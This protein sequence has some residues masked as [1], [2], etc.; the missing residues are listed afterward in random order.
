[1]STMVQESVKERMSDQLGAETS[2]ATIWSRRDFLSLTAWGGVLAF[3]S[4]VSI[5][6][7]R[8]MFP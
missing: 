6:F 3:L 4:T 5:A 7:L 2:E 1:M 8:F